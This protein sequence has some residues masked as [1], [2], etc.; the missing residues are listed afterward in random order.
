SM[1][2]DETHV[3]EALSAGAAGYL[4]KDAADVELI[5]AV[6]S[7]ARHGSYYSPSVQR[8]LVNASLRRRN[9]GGDN[10]ALWRLTPR[11]REIVQLIAEGRSKR[12]IG[13]LLLVSPETVETH[14]RH[15]MKK[16]GARNIAEI[17]RFALRSG[18]VS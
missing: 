12:E 11:E 5:W 13:R 14:R 17:V 6:K 15:V 16:V 4:V 8:V 18:I 2:D 1:H 3:R 9:T 7:V 10:D